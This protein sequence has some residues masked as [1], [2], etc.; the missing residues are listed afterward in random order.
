MEFSEFKKKKLNFFL[1]MLVEQN[2]TE[3]KT[4]S[5]KMI[6]YLKISLIFALG[7][8]KKEERK[9]ANASTAYLVK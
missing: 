1:L 4:A 8:R 2:E 9:P 5:I 3:K 7:A 6:K